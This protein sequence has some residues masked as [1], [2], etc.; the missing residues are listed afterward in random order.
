MFNF[1]SYSLLRFLTNEND[2]FIGYIED[3]LATPTANYKDQK[4][5][6]LSW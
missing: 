2:N 1:A 6:W 5:N 4:L 3:F